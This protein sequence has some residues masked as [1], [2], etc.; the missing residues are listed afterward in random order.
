MNA[1]MLARKS[2]LLCPHTLFSLI[3]PKHKQNANVVGQDGDNK[4]VLAPVVK[5]STVT[6]LENIFEN[7]N[8]RFLIGPILI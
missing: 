6:R 3:L 7:L 8:S 5:D 1:P 4:T 2:S